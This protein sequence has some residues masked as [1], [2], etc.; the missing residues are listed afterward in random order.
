MTNTYI[1]NPDNDLA[2]ANGDANY[3]PPMSARRM[4]TDL[5]FL[6]TWWAND[7]DSILI[8]HSEALYYWSKTSDNSPFSTDIKWITDKEALNKAQ[9]KLLKIPGKFRRFT[10]DRKDEIFNGAAKAVGA[11]GKKKVIEVY[12]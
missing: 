9:T 7:G 3:L 4:A 8:P 2:L 12:E 10:I 1:F 5:A 6:P 11:A